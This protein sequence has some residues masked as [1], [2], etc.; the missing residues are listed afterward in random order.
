VLPGTAVRLLLGFVA[1]VL[2][3]ANNAWKRFVAGAGIV[4]LTIMAYL[5]A[6]RGGFVWDDDFYVTANQSLRSREGLR[7]I[8]TRP[9]MGSQMG[10]QQYYPLSFTG[11]WAQYHLWGLRPFGYHLV[12]VLV[13]ALNAVL[14]WR[15]LRRLEVPGSWWAAAIFALHPVQ[16]ESVAWITEFKNVSSVTFSLLAVLAFLR[17]RPLPGDGT[18]ATGA[19]RFYGLAIALFVCALLCK[20][21]VCCL[22]V[23]L[24]V[25]LWWKLDRVTKRDALMLV[26]WFAVSLA[27]GLITVRVESRLPEDGP[28][29]LVLSAVQRGLLAGRALWFYAGKVFWPHPLAFVYP[30]WTIDAS[31]PW[32]YLFP[33]AALALVIALWLLRRQIGKG[34]LAGTLCFVVMLAPV[35]GFFDIYFFRFSYVTDHFQYLACVGLIALAAGVGAALAQRAGPRGREWGT[36]VGGV[37]LVV[38]GGSTWGQ[39]HIYRD[40]ETL[41]RDTLA[42]NPKAW[43]AHNNLGNVLR[44]QGKTMEAI[45]HYEQVLELEPDYAEAHK[46]LGFALSLVGNA[47]AAAAHYE[48]ALRITPDD[49]HVRNNLGNVLLR[50]GRVQEAIAQYETVLRSSPGFAETHY[51]LGLALQQAGRFQEAVGQFEQAARLEPDSAS[52]HYNWGLALAQLGRLSEAVEHWETALRIDPDYAEAHYNLGIA[53]ERAGRVAEAI[54]HYERAVQLRPDYAR[55]RNRLARLQAAR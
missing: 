18:A 38:L 47:G 11:L 16:V 44:A 49:T 37:I 7:R 2:Q 42:K 52:A 53:L 40:P 48:K 6:L 4:L 25:L 23:A 26:P 55:A 1:S 31:A 21:A 5:P 19:W 30:R 27:L 20:T 39:T 28:S 3:P 36:L 10:P 15:V 29:G 9:G 33:A 54:G 32:Q 34:P 22:P 13:H 43:I 12:N 46:N 35:L 45:E 50:L 17:F 8:W 14:L 24:A 51:N 41:W